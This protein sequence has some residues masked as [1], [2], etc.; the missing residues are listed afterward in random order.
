[1]LSLRAVNHYYGN[2]HTLWDVDLDLQPGKCTGVLGLPG[3]GK[4]TLAN[5]IIGNLPIE[6]GTMVW[7]QAGA[8]P[9]DLRPMAMVNRVALGIR[10][11]SQERRIFSQLTVEENLHIARKA[12]GE[13]EAMSCSDIY[14]LFPQLYSLRQ[15]KGGVLSEDDQHQLA[16]AST[17]VTRPRLLILDEPTRGSGQAYIH[18]LGNLIVRLSQE[19]GIAIMLAEQ[20]LPFIRRVADCYCLL[21][22]G[23]NVAQG[24]L[25][26]RNDP[27][28]NDLM[29]PEAKR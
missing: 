5:C 2:Q 14:R 13:N 19:L 9:C 11:V 16:L 20:S 18:K 17:L 6:S 28:L 24:L 23:R 26:Q 21:H 15:I 3:M 29:A 7:Y 8:P 10:Y 1:M 25:A 27:F 22:R 12:I 4:T